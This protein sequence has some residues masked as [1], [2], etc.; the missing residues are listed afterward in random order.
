LY[1]KSSY[2]KKLL[3]RIQVYVQIV[4]FVSALSACRKGVE[5]D[6]ASLITTKHVFATDASA[7]SVVNSIYSAMFYERFTFA[8][9]KHS[10]GLLTGLAG[11]E[12]RGIPDEPF[13]LF[14]TN[15]LTP[16]RFLDSYFW[17]QLYSVIYT[18]NVSLE[19]IAGSEGMS[20]AVKKQLTGEVKFMRGFLY[21]QLVNLFGAVPMA[22]TSDYRINR[23]LPRLS[24]PEV[25]KQ[26]V[27]DLTDAQSALSTI[28]LDGFGKEVLERVRPNRWV[29][30][31][32]LARVYLYLQDWAA[33]E[34]QAEMVLS[35]PDFLLEPDLDLVFLST[36][37]EGIFQIQ[38]HLLP[39]TEDFRV[40]HLNEGEGLSFSKP[41]ILSSGLIRSFDT[42]D[43]RYNKWIGRSMVEI[44]DG[45][46]P[47]AHFYANKY[48]LRLSPPVDYLMV[49]RLAEQYLIRAEA[50]AQQGN[51]AGG[52]ADLDVIRNRAGLPMTSV[53]TKQELLG[54]IA[55][56]RQHELFT[57]WGHRWFDLK[58]TGAMDSVMTRVAAEK[59]TTWQPHYKLFPIPQTEID[60]NPN[61]AQNPGY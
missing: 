14:Y 15:N 4:L 44:G 39:F 43:A 61:L 5:T 6:S 26:I 19:G 13:G 54:A 56:E 50:R 11:D 8:Q 38:L 2:Y 30:A 22:T 31:A 28:Y 34:A 47:R 55:Q 18:C 32:M 41:A 12:L 29:A 57:E 9:G 58:R 20:R 37:R 42:G 53:T 33:A 45:V 3:G 48:K 40:Y 10:I 23:A 21:F 46:R 49:L 24:L 17:K 7:I 35:N 60:S 51:V 36:S 27:K 59:G 52:K 16:D 1:F 25:Y